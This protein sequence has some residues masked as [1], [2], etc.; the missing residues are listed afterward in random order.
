MSDYLIFHSS[1]MG[2]NHIVKGNVCQDSSISYEDDV[3]KIIIVADGHG[4]SACCRSDYGAKMASEVAM[5]QL[6]IFAR[7]MQTIW[8]ENH[9]EY[10][11]FLQEKHQKKKIKTLTD[12][13]IAKWHQKIMENLKHFPLS[14]KEYE[15]VGEYAVEYQ[16]GRKLPHI[17]GSTLIAALW[18]DSVLVLLQQGDGRCN[19]FY[20][21][22][23]I[24]QPIPWDEHCHANVTTSLCDD[25]ASLTI[26]SC[27]IDLQEI[28]VIAC[29]LGSDGVEDSYRTMEGNYIFY[30]EFMIEIMERNYEKKKVEEY[31]EEY[32]PRFS[33]IGSGDDISVAAIVD[34]D[35]FTKEAKSLYEEEVRKYLLEEELIMINE[36][37]ISM[38][39]KHKILHGRK[40][41][42][43]EAMKDYEVYHQKYNDYIQQKIDVEIKLKNYDK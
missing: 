18:I 3:C 37:I 8:E 24:D 21:N 22:L 30:K 14:V 1:C 40:E 5:E 32:L 43:N 33:Q 27:V 28:P 17:F 23:E 35:A 41:C 39:R 20:G 13:I 19:I 12:S 6:Q 2:Y 29:F 38:E 4:A 16:A 15:Q 42:S 9:K 34:K 25:D 26:R 11:V 36:K 31:L 7:E 10:E